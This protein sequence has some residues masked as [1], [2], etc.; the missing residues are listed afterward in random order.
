MNHY[1]AIL[2]VKPGSNIREI[3]KAYRRAVI[4]YHPDTNGGRGNTDRFKEVVT[5][6]KALQKHYKS[7]GVKQTAPQ[8]NSNFIF[9]RIYYSLR[10]MIKHS[11]D[12]PQRFIR[13]RKRKIYDG[14]FI[15]PLVT[16]I[17]YEDLKLRFYESNNIHVRQQAAR[18]LA[19]NNAKEAVDILKPELETASQGFLVEL[20]FCFG[21]IP[22]DSSIKILKRFA[23]S[24]DIRVACAAVNALQNI[25]RELARKTLSS[26]IRDG[27]GLTAIFT[28]RAEAKEV[29]KLIKLGLFEKSEFY[30]ARAVR[31]KTGLPLQVVLKELGWII[32]STT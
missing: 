26:V 30:I 19:Y 21:L 11:S 16:S 14:T 29:L 22:L 20:I 8:T 32:P 13:P 28:K 4:K 12:A 27:K 15:D 24:R 3:K 23:G 9:L 25:D 6:Y 31:T 5:A 18:A 1:F 17:P 10:D 2:R 7:I